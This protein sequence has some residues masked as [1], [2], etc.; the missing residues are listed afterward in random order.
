[1]MPTIDLE[2]P[3]VQRIVEEAV[4]AGLESPLREPILE[5]VEGTTGGSVEEPSR[6]P[7][8]PADEE[9]PEVDATGD[10]EKRRTTK[11]I[12]GLVVFVTMFVVL[13]ITLRRLTDDE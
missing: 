8:E 1:M 2:D 11:A 9:R 4:R 7:V 3:L 5:A 13:Y 6:E 10:G 12:Q